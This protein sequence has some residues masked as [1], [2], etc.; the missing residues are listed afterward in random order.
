MKVA[1][2]G[3]GYWGPNLIRNFSANKLVKSVVGCD[4]D[5]QR[6]E[7]LKISF[8][9]I[10]IEKDYR[11]LFSSPDIDAVC[12]STPVN[13]HYQLAREALES[14]KHVWVEKPFTA[15]AWQAEELITIAQQQRR[16]LFVDHT[17]IYHSP[18]IKIKEIIGSGEIGDILYYDSVRINLGLFQRDVNVIWD[19]APH[20]FSIMNYLLGKRVTAISANGIA[21]IN[22]L[23]NIAQVSAYFDDKCFAHF[24]LNWTSP[25]KIRRII[26]GGNRKMIVYDDLE[27]S[28]KVKI[29]NSGVELVAQKDI[30]HA[31]IQ[32]RVGD[33]YSPHIDQQEALGRATEEF[34]SSVIENRQ[35]LTSGHDG[36]FVV[37]MIEAANQS[38]N[39]KGSLLEV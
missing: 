32:Y 7:Q 12:I 10:A 2:I 15:E 18:V 29:Y 13:T 9:H 1:V 27:S 11:K 36:L 38:L 19:L 8:P 23:E 25:V 35:P 37:K 28:E 34:V 5:Q 20:D 24:H 6:L 22:K 16:V 26:I 31:L 30:H 3:L 4:M 14:G 33:M 17:F 21:S 39:Q